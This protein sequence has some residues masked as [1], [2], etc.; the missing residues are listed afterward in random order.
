MTPD[1]IQK[2]S[3]MNFADLTRLHNEAKTKRL[4][5]E[6]S[7]KSEVDMLKDIEDTIKHIVGI[8]FNEMGIDNV[9]TEYGTPYVSN[10]FEAKADMPDEFL[11]Y[12]V[13]NRMWNL[14]DIKPN[15]SEVKRYLELN[16]V[17]PPGVDAHWV[18][19]ININTAGSKHK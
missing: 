8:K 18:R 16:K 3:E 5:K 9:K 12:V 7:I 17:C 6:A 2:L 11:R 1:K 15:K 4:A 10:L 13:E 14:L 19:K